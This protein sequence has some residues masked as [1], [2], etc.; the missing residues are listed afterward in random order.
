MKSTRNVAN[1][2]L[3]GSFGRSAL[4]SPCRR[5]VSLRLTGPHPAGGNHNDI[6]Y[7]YDASGRVVRQY[8]SWTNRSPLVRG[9]RKTEYDYA[10]R[11]TRA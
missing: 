2:A 1:P 10:G 6:H 7:D 3:R 9:E 11:V 8:E 5:F 4:K